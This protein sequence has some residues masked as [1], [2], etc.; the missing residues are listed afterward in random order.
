L[1]PVQHKVKDMVFTDWECTNWETSNLS[2]PRAF[3]KTVCTDYG[4]QYGDKYQGCV[5]SE[6]VADFLPQTIK[7]STET[8]KND[9]SN[10]P[11]VVSYVTFPACK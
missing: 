4:P 3:E 5:K 10:F 7:I 9:R 11:G 1:V 6:K 2:Y 8:F